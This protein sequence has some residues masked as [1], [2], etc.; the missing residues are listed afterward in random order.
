MLTLDS[1]SILL[2]IQLHRVQPPPSCTDCL[3]DLID[4][5]V[6]RIRSRRNGDDTEGLD[7]YCNRIKAQ[8]KVWTRKKRRVVFHPGSLFSFFSF[9]CQPFFS[10]RSQKPHPRFPRRE[11]EG[12][13]GTLLCILD[14]PSHDVQSLEQYSEDSIRSSEGLERET[15]S[16]EFELAQGQE[17]PK[18]CSILE[19]DC[20]ACQ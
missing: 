18:M 17:A 3:T 11:R 5:R 19:P 12:E 1:L 8:H 13:R 4:E 7:H 16:N 20:D 10:S 9:V 2:L 6:T 14:Q 15:Q